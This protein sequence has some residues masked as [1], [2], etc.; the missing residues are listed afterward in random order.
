MKFTILYL[1]LGLLFIL[2]ICAII[3]VIKTKR[4]K[5][6][7]KQAGND[8]EKYFNSIIT[9]ILN[10]EDILMNNVELTVDGKKTEIDN[11]IINANGIFIIE[12]KN[13]N[14]KLYGNADDFEWIK[15]KVSPSGEIYTKTVKNPIKQMKRQ[16]YI[17]SKYLKNN[18]FKIWINGYVYFAQ[19]NCPVKDYCVITDI[20]EFE[21]E[22]HSEQH[23]IYD[24]NTIN[25]VI[26]V[27]K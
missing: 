15:R 3:I 21:K 2:Y 6:E 4:R 13:Y 18:G 20:N 5:K 7:I 23:K 19:N 12:V 17:L 22:I 24:K 27:L 9:K 10:D 26:N 11:L 25:E 1:I 16:T 8:G 14:G